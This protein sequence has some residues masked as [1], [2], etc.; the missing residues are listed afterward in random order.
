MRHQAIYN[1][2][3]NVVTISERDGAFDE[4]GKLVELDENLIQAEVLQ[5]QQA[6]AATEY[7]RQRAS[8]YPPL[9]DL[10]DALYWQAQGNS[11]PMTDYLAACQAV[12]ARY[13]KGNTNA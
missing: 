6:W 5:L 4:K 8:E 11:Q 10:A 1:L 13:P 3:N 12:K 7:Q 2:Y 9:Q